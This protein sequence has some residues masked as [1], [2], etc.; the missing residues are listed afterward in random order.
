MP[1]REVAADPARSSAPVDLA[2]VFRD[3]DLLVVDKPAGLAMHPGTGVHDHLLGRVHRLLGASRGHSF[4]VA[5]AHRLDRD[6]SGLV[7]FGVS[8]QG[9]RGFTALLRDHAVRKTYLARVHG[10]PPP[11]GEI[12]LSLARHDASV[13]P[14]M[15]VQADGVAALTR[16]RVVATLAQRAVL[17]VELATGRTHQIRAHFAAIGYPL[18]GDH[19]YGRAD[20]ARRLCLHA[21]RLEFAHPIN[22][23]ALCLVAT[24][25]PELR[26]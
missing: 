10:L 24:P 14:K 23:D 2:V 5:P 11:Q 13:G 1:R 19:R 4:R 7:V 3:E 15:H 22:G 25:P 17:E 12:D 8:A 20:G 21:W 26:A 16:Y 9:L 18:V 6:T